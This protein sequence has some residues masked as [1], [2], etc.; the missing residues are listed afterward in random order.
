LIFRKK[1]RNIN[2]TINVKVRRSVISNTYND[3]SRKDRIESIKR[4]RTVHDIIGEKGMEFPPVEDISYL[5]KFASYDPKSQPEENRSYSALIRTE[6]PAIIFV[7]DY[8]EQNFGKISEGEEDMANIAAERLSCMRTHAT[9]ISEA[10]LVLVKTPV[11]YSGSKKLVNLV[12]G[13][14]RSDPYSN[15][16]KDHKI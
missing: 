6:C 16:H 7:D 13:I 10:A 8:M 11:F 4:V 15:S 2:L 5:K 14:Y 12:D 9:P 1:V 3:T